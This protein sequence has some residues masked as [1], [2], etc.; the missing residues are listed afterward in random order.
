MRIV[1]HIVR[2]TKRIKMQD[3][4]CTSST[5]NSTLHTPQSKGF[6]LIEAIITIVIVGIISSIAALIILEG[7]KASAKEQNL[8]GVHYQA[9][10]AMERMAREIRLI[11]SQTAGDIPTM[12][13]TDLIFCDVTGR[14]VEFQLAGLVLNRRES[15][16]C[17][18]FAWGG[19]Y[20]LTSGGVNPLTFTYLDSAGAGGATAANLWF[21]DINLTDTQGS[22]S[23]PMRSRVH[24]MNF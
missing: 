8:S 3:A 6:T 2:N 9:R 4:S 23:L 13:A 14:A 20:T 11:R 10:I 24:P 18:P 15:A 17:T 16:T 21:V 22:D 12:A 5:P 7:V 19:W 1:G